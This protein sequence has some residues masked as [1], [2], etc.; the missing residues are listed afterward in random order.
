MLEK[1]KI[2][3]VEKTI[4]EEFSEPHFLLRP[5]PGLQHNRLFVRKVFTILVGM[6]NFSSPNSHKESSH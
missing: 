6:G 3:Y 4:R 2:I 5:P 1:E